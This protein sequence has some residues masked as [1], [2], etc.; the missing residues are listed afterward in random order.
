[1]KLFFSAQGGPASG[2]KII[3]FILFLL[4][5]GAIFF[6]LTNVLLS[7]TSESENQ[8]TV[9]FKDNCFNVEIVKTTK[10]LSDGLMFRQQLDKN[11]GM[12]FIFSKEDIYPFW[13]KNTL[14]PLDMI[15]INTENKIVFIEENA[16]PCLSNQ[17]CDRINPKV[18][19]KYVLEINSGISEKLGLRVGD[20]VLLNF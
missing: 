4:I 20:E 5:F 11:R 10:E 19:A 18:K 7:P 8:P 12:L 9:C 14:I 2:W 3:L 17:E 13:M 1:M 16:E 15:W 6:A